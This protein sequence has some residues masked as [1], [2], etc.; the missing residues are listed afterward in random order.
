MFHHDT[1]K[2]RSYH[3]PSN[4]MTFPVLKPIDPHL[5]KPTT[6]VSPQPFPAPRARSV[7]SIVHVCMNP[8]IQIASCSTLNDKARIVAQS[9]VLGVWMITHVASSPHLL[10]M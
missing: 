5:R 8:G 6:E 4:C 3:I 9:A 10:H 2:C 1:M 7:C